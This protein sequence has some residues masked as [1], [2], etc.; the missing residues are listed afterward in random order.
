MRIEKFSI[1]NFK[2]IKLAEYEDLPNFDVLCGGH[3][4][5][6]SSILEALM[7]S[8]EALGSYGYFKRNPNAVSA[9][10]DFCKMSIE[11]KFSDEELKYL[12]DLN[13]NNQVGNN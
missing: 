2:N 7:T 9:Y 13:P 10:A 1:K 6:E 11:P 5:G 4:C 12:K 8:K 3:D